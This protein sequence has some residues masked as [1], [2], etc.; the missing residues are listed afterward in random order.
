MG[1]HAVRVGYDQRALA[2]VEVRGGQRDWEKAE[3]ELH[4][5]YADALG[6]DPEDLDVPGIWQVLA[7]GKLLSFL[8]PALFVPAGWGIAKHVHASFVRPG[9]DTNVLLYVA[10]Q[11]LVIGLV[12]VLAVN[13]ANDAAEAVKKAAT[14]RKSPPPYF[15]V[16]AE[17]TCVEPTVARKQ[18]NVQGGELRPGLPY[19]SF[20]V[21]GDDVVLWDPDTAEPFKVPTGQVR[22]LPAKEPREACDFPARKWERQ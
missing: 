18:L 14:E 20:G 19:L 8:S 6:L 21:A 10:A 11:T 15:G 7:A 4:A 22:L 16:E 1:A 13:S 3:D 5:L 17:W 9:E 12:A 2:L